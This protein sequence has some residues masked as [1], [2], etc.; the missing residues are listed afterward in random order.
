MSAN[1]PSD[2]KPGRSFDSAYGFSFAVAIGLFLFIGGLVITLMLGGGSMTGL[3]FGIPLLLAGLIVPLLMMRSLFNKNEVS[4]PCPYCSHQITT[5][6]AT[7]LLE[8]PNCKR[9]V[10]V[11]DEQLHA[12]ETPDPR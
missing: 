4:G 11:R 8:C 2:E 7:I 9:V 12:T 6:D 1:E 5:S 3:I 10:S